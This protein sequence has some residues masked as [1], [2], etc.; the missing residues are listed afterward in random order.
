[1][2]LVWIDPDT[3]DILAA[4]GDG[5]LVRGAAAKVL[6]EAHLSRPEPT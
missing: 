3:V 5:L 1:M 2:P 4:L 6:P